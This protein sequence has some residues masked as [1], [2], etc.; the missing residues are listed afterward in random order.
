[1]DAVALTRT[2][3]PKST[4][5]DVPGLEN[6]VFTTTAE[7]WGQA[8]TST[9]WSTAD[10]YSGVSRNS[11]PGDGG[12]TS[13]LDDDFED[14]AKMINAELNELDRDIVK[15]VATGGED[16]AQLPDTSLESLLNTDNLDLKSNGT[17][18]NLV[19]PKIEEI[20]ME[21]EENPTISSLNPVSTQNMPPP[22]MPSAAFG[23]LPMDNFA[24]DTKPSLIPMNQADLLEAG[25]GF[26]GSKLRPMNSPC[27]FGNA[28][29]TGERN[30]QQKAPT[31]SHLNTGASLNAPMNTS[32]TVPIMNIS[33][34]TQ[35]LQTARG[36][37]P[38]MNTTQSRNFGRMPQMP[39]SDMSS[40]GNG[41]FRVPAPVPPIPK[42]NDMQQQFIQLIR[43][44]APQDSYSD[45]MVVDLVYDMMT[46]ADKRKDEDMRL[47][48]LLQQGGFAQ[49][50]E[51]PEI[52]IKQEVVTPTL[53]Q[54]T[55]S[56]PS[57]SDSMAKQSS[58]PQVF[59][60]STSSFTSTDSFNQL[61]GNRSTLG[62]PLPTI[63]P[64][65]GT[66]RNQNPP[67]RFQ[68]GNTQFVSQGDNNMN[69][70]MSN[71]GVS[72]TQTGATMPNNNLWNSST[73][74]IKQNVMQQ[75]LRN[76]LQS[77]NSPPPKQNTNFQTSQVNSGLLPQ[78]PNMPFLPQQGV[79]NLMQQNGTQNT[80]S[81]MFNTTVVPNL[82][83]MN[84]QELSQMN[85]LLQSAP[86]QGSS[87][88]NINGASMSIGNQH[89]LKFD[90]NRKL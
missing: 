82:D 39:R 61:P 43:E 65:N 5:A 70:L 77:T 63:R 13:T 20:P 27:M 51:V 46:D 54:P 4:G 11:A 10:R 62:T 76:L 16:V 36:P 35:N 34:Q 88:Q 7:P 84:F 89:Y 32:S 18:Q 14:W 8:S 37:N 1:M 81:N 67:V 47:A 12:S 40:T 71:A 73:P 85:S 64:Q 75:G 44:I 55:S 69:F 87:F 9:S 52:E 15:Y 56:F 33:Q 42:Q 58:P 25:L 72:S 78:Q 6:D 50:E 38:A 60:S 48:S 2:G 31:L 28:N 41:N 74:A 21:S 30:Y 17:V 22:I 49:I 23:N 57:F 83:Q 66:V 24:A 3:Y 19:T 86:L 45:Q 53:P 90:M 68:N 59:S 80:Q 79:T 29:S 26:T